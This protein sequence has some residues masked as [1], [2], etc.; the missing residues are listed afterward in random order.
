MSL[1]ESA[2]AAV[3]EELSFPTLSDSSAALSR[4][5]VRA[6]ASSLC[7]LSVFGELRTTRDVAA[8]GTGAEGV[9]PGAFVIPNPWDAGSARILAAL[10]FEALATT[11]AG[12]AFTLGRRDSGG[13]L[14]RDEALAVGGR[15]EHLAPRVDDRRVP[16]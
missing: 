2:V 10:G 12:L 3:R 6:S 14:G 5:P 8:G 15:G 9:A 13:L 4:K 16:I 1:P 7:R 11:S